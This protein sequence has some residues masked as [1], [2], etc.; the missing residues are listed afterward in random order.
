MRHFLVLHNEESQGVAKHED[1][2]A[3]SSKKFRLHNTDRIWVI[4]RRGK[5]PSQDYFLWKT[6]IYEKTIESAES[7]EDIYKFKYVGYKG[8]MFIPP[9]P[10]KKLEWFPQFNS[11]MAHFV[12]MREIVDELYI[13][14]LSK[15]LDTK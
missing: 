9:I 7:R 12:G 6:F 8:K 1:F 15:Y 2:L 5:R 10:L 4:V 3:S 14:L 11:K 13:K